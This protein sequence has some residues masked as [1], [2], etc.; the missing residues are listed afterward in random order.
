MREKEPKAHKQE[1]R[2]REKKKKEKV[3]MSV[4]ERSKQM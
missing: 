3:G 2:K 4:L 1:E